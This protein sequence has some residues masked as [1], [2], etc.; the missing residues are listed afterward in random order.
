MRRPSLAGPLAT[1]L[2]ASVVSAAGCSR[3]G[4][5]RRPGP[6]AARFLPADA[7]AA[8]VI[9][10]LGE[11][12][13]QA[14]ALQAA[15]VARPGAGDLGTLRTALGAQLGVDL[16]DP[17]SLAGAGLDPERGL[18]A[19]LLPAGS[20]AAGPQPVLVLPAGDAARLQAFVDRLARDRLGAGGP[21][22]E[23]G[24]VLW[25]QAPGSP[26]VLSL[27]FTDGSAL[28][29]PG[30]GGADALRALLRLEPARS[31]DESPA[32]RRLQAALG[33]PAA[34][35]ASVPAG[36]P[37]L[38]TIPGLPEIQ[39]LG[40]LAAGLSASERG[41]RLVL[42]AL[43]APEEARLRPL[44][45]PGAGG[46]A[47]AIA[48]DAAVGLRLSADLGT[49]LPLLSDRLPP[50]LAP[51]KDL[52]ASLSSPID[53]GLTLAPG[54][55]LARALAGR[56]ADPLRVLR[57]EL[58]APLPAG[59]RAG[60][61]LAAQVGS[62][63]THG[64][65]GW[66]AR[67]HDGTE[68]AWSTS[69]ARL[70]LVAGPDAATAPTAAPPAGFTAPTPASER[71]LAGGLGGLVVHVDNLVRAVRSLPSSAYGA[72][73]DAVVARSLAQKLAALPGRGA[74]VSLRADL[75]E[76]A[77]RLALEIELGAPPG[78]AP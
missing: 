60:E 13:R 32:W 56:E 20:G 74:A 12:S 63:T 36:S 70:H 6:G 49:A 1:I 40:G 62:S 73:P 52:A 33:E 14:A 30:P 16:F 71:A 66:R 55:S 42:A 65:E 27:A 18:A 59:S 78:T 22:H 46:A 17:A 39:A 64:P 28:L 51:L 57:L 23:G 67:R 58:S 7:V 50:S 5:P 34:A 26:P 3:C 44:A 77:L 54:A 38:G 48:P 37:A 8:L 53:V 21:S 75:P 2:L 31:L 45:G 72:G 10:R 41:A 69:G 43:L 9:P 61:A 47:A 11:A 29:A 25:R 76:G 15:L 24:L 19:A 35:L 4:A 68:L